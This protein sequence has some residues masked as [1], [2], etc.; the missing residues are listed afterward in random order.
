VTAD[1]HTEGS[2]CSLCG[3]PYNVAAFAALLP[4]R[5]GESRY[6]H[7]ECARVPDS[8]GEELQDLIFAALVPLRILGPARLAW[9][10]EV[11][12]RDV[13]S[14]AEVTTGEGERLLAAAH[15]LLGAAS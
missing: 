13:R 8:M 5:A 2:H 1:G 7:R 10:G 15:E 14:F 6:V 12:G 4:G 3:Q 11:L 9:A